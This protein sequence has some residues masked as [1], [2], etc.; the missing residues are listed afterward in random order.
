MHSSPLPQG[1]FSA[2]WIPT[3][4]AGAVDRAALANK[5]DWR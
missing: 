4:A 5:R 2:Q 3:D 1:I